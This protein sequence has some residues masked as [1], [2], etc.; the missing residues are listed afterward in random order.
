M[1]G[2]PILLVTGPQRKMRVRELKAIQVIF[3]R[4]PCAVVIEEKWLCSP[5]LVVVD[6][7]NIMIGIIF[8]EECSVVVPPH[9]PLTT[10]SF[11]FIFPLLDCFNACSC[12]Q[13]SLSCYFASWQDINKY[14]V[15]I[16]W[17]GERSKKGNMKTRKGTSIAVSCLEFG[18]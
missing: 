1:Y 13:Q 11:P 9:T 5:F 16:P 18:F 8:V 7:D 12:A 17:S 6:A 15:Y 14:D 10:T 2:I 4:Y 3:A